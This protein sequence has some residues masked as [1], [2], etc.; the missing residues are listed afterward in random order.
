FYLETAYSGGAAGNTS[1]LYFD[2]LTLT[3]PA[4]PVVQDITGIKD[5]LPF[6]VG[7]AVSSPEL[8]GAKAQLLVKHFDQVTPENYM[9]PEAWYDAN[10][11]FV[12]TNTEADELM[13]FA[14]QNNLRVYGHNL[15]WYQQTPD[16]FFQH[17]DGTWLTNSPAD[18]AILR[19]R[20]DAHVDSV[21]KYLSDEFGP[22]GSATNPLVAFDVVNEAVSDNAG[23]PEG[24]RQSHWY[25]VLGE[26]YI[27]EAFND[28]EQAFNVTYAAP[29][30][31]HPVALFLNDYNTEQ[32][33]KRARMA[34]LVDRL[35]ADGVPI[36]GVGHQFHVTL[37]TPVSTLKDAIDAFDGIRTADGHELWQAITELDVPTGTPVTQAALIDQGYYYRAVFDMLRAE[38]A[39]GA[40]IFS[41]T[42][43]GMTDGQSWRAGSGAPLLFDDDLQAK[44]AYLGVTDQPL[45]AKQLSAVVFA[46]DS[47][48]ADVTSPDATAAVEWGQLPL[49]P[50][51]DAAGFQLRW[52]PDHLT[53][54][55]SVADATADATDAV[56]FTWG[57]GSGSGAGVTATVHRDGSVAGA[58]V[59]AQVASTA[60]GWKAVVDLPIALT[61]SATPGFDV[62]VTDGTTTAGWN[63]PGNLGTL[64]L[65][66][67]L[68]STQIPQASTAPS[69]D[70]TRDAVW[71]QAST[72]TTGKL[73]SGAAGG[74]SATVY[75]L[76]QDHYLYVL[77]DV[78]DPTID[79]S[80]PN[81]YEQDSVEIFTDPGN[82]KNGS[83]R[84][85]DAQMRISA[86]NVVSFGAGD[87][88]AQ[89]A[90]LTSA[91]ARTATGYVVE[92]RIDLLDQAGPGTFQ[93][94][95]YEVND[96][97]GGARTSNVGWAEQTGSAY[98]TTARWGVAR[99]V[100]PRPP[101]T[102]DQL[103]GANRGPVDLPA[104]VRQGD[105][106]TVDLGRQHAGE[107]VDVWLYSDPAQLPGVTAS[108]RGAVTITVPAGTPKGEHRIALFT[109]GGALLGWDSLT[110]IG[111]GDPAIA[112]VPPAISGTPAE[113]QLLRATTG[114]WAP[115]G[116][117]R[118][119]FQWQRDGTAIPWATG[120]VYAVQTADAGHALTVVVTA[121]ATGFPA[122][123]ATSLPVTVALPLVAPT[124]TRQPQDVSATAGATVTFTAQA[125]GRPEPTVRWQSRAGH[126]VWR[127]VAQATSPTLV[128]PV[129]KA[130]DGTS[131]R[132]VFTNAA[133]SATTRAA[134]LTVKPAP[135]PTPPH[136]PCGVP[137]HWLPLPW[138][139]PAAP[140][141][142]WHRF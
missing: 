44:P 114:T 3:K 25:Q 60:S 67:P 140:P 89:A 19:Q 54:Y 28:A 119:A 40:Q 111:A 134:T 1:D 127:D 93:G 128:V 94:V 62:T 8:V 110:V 81:A 91:T 49:H 65:V 78:T 47:S 131:Y 115:A 68:S 4:P 30:V 69:I 57:S 138:H 36:D 136:G 58:G 77:A 90:R 125:S 117:L 43:W 71:S 96:G 98:Q 126:G 45:P 75:Q 87:E 46:Q 22:F 120:P 108:A 82:A 124:I 23:D 24:L 38:F 112:L 73:I 137:L 35:I 12:A 41:A 39:A 64:Q 7:V 100:G 80:S 106:V 76:W 104:V 95:D 29:G 34:D 141:W 14:Q 56:A 122:A 50:A 105:T 53:A 139:A 55:V 121:T 92:A 20:L 15:V 27:E 101:L 63:T 11:H 133:G 18:Q 99:L 10:H 83:Y 48:D 61:Q 135:K 17:D 102:G 59:T 130:L 42:V 13:A 16:W 72:V 51:G 79:T 88:A 66:E 9:K 5:T 32:T 107:P 6:P 21:A 109:P 113:R 70:G 84:P 33:G 97:T 103:T 132:A 116:G 123:S 37:S 142:G 129:T 74:A 85:D 26:S 86:D 2:D 52:S 31:T 118:F